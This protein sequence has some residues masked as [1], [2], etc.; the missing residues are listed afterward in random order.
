M[1]VSVDIGCDIKIAVWQTDEW[2]NQYP[3]NK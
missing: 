3:L 2:R 1:D